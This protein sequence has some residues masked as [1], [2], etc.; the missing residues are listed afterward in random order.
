MPVLD[1][2]TRCRTFDEVALGYSEKAAVS[3]AKRCL[4]CGCQDFFECGLF[5][6]AAEYGADPLRFGASK[7]RRLDVSDHP[8]IERNP[9]KCVLCGLCV[10]MCDE[11]LGI[12]ALGFA[13]RGDET[14]A[15][16]AMRAPLEKTDCVS[17]GLCVHACPTGALTERIPLRKSVPVSEVAYET[18]CPGCG[19][20]C[21]VVVTQVSGKD[22]AENREP[23]AEKETEAADKP[24]MRVLPRKGGILC[25]LGRFGLIERDWA[26]EY[27]YKN[28]MFVNISD[29]FEPSELD[30]INL[31]EKFLEAVKEADSAERDQQSRPQ[32]QTPRKWR[33]NGYEMEGLSELRSVILSGEMIDINAGTLGVSLSPGLTNGEMAEAYALAKE[34]GAEIFTLAGGGAADEAD[35]GELLNRM[36]HAAPLKKHDKSELYFINEY[37][38]RRGLVGLGVTRREN[39]KGIDALIAFGGTPELPQLDSICRTLAVMPNR[40]LFAHGDSY[41][42]CDGKVIETGL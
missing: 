35:P 17:C 6:Y 38:N 33:V 42:R 21:E 5:K 31:T 24:I 41:T 10:R 25:G 1:P 26:W 14:Q 11:A 39:L 28:S 18:V 30:N 22:R 3:E 13:G 9:D 7:R 4:E 20:L 2:Q 27:Y 12:G 34:L 16:P 37:P 8:F 36:I 19:A 23:R 29:I 32:S 40:G 15:V